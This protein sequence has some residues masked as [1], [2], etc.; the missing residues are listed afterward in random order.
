MKQSGSHVSGKHV[1]SKALG[2]MPITMLIIFIEIIW[3]VIAFIWLRDYK[4]WIQIA[5]TAL[6]LLVISYLILKDEN[7]SYKMTWIIVIGI[8]PLMGAMMY[9]MFG[10]KRPSRHMRKRLERVDAM[11]RECMLQRTPVLPA[12]TDDRLA[13]TSTYLA[14][15]GPFPAYADTDVEYFDVGEKLFARLLPDLESAQHY[16]FME[17]FIVSEG[18]IWEEVFDVL[19]RRA[20]AGVDVR[21]IYDDMGSVSSLPRNMKK[22]LRSAGIRLLAFNPFLPLVSLVMNHR[23]HRK[24]TVIDGRVAYT[25]GINIADEYANRYDRYGH[26][27]DTGLRMEG[28][29]VN[30]FAVMFLNMWNAFCKGETDYTPYLT[31]QPCA[32]AAG[33]GIVQPY[34][35]SPLD[36]ENLAENVYLEILSQAQ[37]YVYIFTPYLVVGSELLSAL[38]LAAKRGVD[39]RIVTPG[40][41]D[42]KTV[43]RLTRSYYTQLVRAGVKIY[44][45]SPGF[46]HAKSFVSDDRVAV[47]GT[48]N[49]DFRSLYLHFECGALLID[50][51]VIEDIRRDALDTIA[52]SREVLPTDCKKY[53]FP[54]L[55]DLILRV[56]S[57]LL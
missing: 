23:D 20:A 6:S 14:R 43:Y 52:I 1:A 48:I 54:S 36:E 45:Y 44:E 16:I 50:T 55:L 53:S 38:T 39:V 47:V 29:A 57:P 31:A 17:Y 34:C 28:M 15:R 56:F 7:P 11:H 49:M 27:K 40:V 32:A 24:I 19:Q 10:N 12:E 22:K 9:L 5:M 42:K 21:L 13:G 4:G 2:R 51:P 25:G 18:S 3:M 30:S 37:R 33:R 41:P 26:W 35:D 46:L 8:M